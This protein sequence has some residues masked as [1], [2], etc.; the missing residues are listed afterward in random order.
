MFLRHIRSNDVGKATTI[1]T[2]AAMTLKAK[3]VSKVIAAKV[4]QNHF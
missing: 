3:T 2:N 1:L 4:A